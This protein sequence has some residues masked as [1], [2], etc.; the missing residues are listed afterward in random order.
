LSC[1]CF[2][3]VK[4]DDFVCPSG[5]VCNETAQ[6]SQGAFNNIK[7]D[8]CTFEML[9]SIQTFFLCQRTIT[10]NSEQSRKPEILFWFFPGMAAS[11]LPFCSFA[12]AS[13]PISEENGKL[14]ETIRFIHNKD[15]KK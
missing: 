14:A 7:E 8:A 13:V 1:V 3:N 5:D 11:L 9:G 6:I 2:E 15:G 4:T 12:S 10:G